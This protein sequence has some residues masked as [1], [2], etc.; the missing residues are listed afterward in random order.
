MRPE[1]EFICQM[2]GKEF[3]MAACFAKFCPECKADAYRRNNRKYQSATKIG[4][5]VDTDEMMQMCLNCTRVK[6][7]GECEEL[8]SL[9]RRIGHGKECTA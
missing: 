6:C 5:K 4:R 1:K 9:S 7:H 2:C 8:A 3:R